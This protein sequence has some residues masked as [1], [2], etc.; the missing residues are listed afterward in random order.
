MLSVEE[1][2]E[3]MKKSESCEREK[4]WEKP[5]TFYTHRLFPAVWSV[6]SV[7]S[8]GVTSSLCVFR[9]IY[10]PLHISDAHRRVIIPP[11]LWVSA[12]ALVNIHSLLWISRATPE[13]QWEKKKTNNM[14]E[15]WAELL[16]A[17]TSHGIVTDVGLLS[18][19]FPGTISD[20]SHVHRRHHDLRGVAYLTNNQF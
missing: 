11:L 3:R 4:C 16:G 20:L 18:S 13:K 7:W 17:L 9:G 6:D 10:R 1:G 14:V 2:T 5:S 8:E 12:L 15:E 19:P